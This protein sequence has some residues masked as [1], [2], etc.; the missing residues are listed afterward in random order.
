MTHLC[1]IYIENYKKLRQVGIVIDPHYQYNLNIQERCLTI[2]KK[3]SIP[4]S[5]WGKGCIRYLPLL[6]EMGLVKVRC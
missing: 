3:P 5:F 6:V 4:N 1:Y 2:E